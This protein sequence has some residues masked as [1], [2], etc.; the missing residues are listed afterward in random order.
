MPH[1]LKQVDNV[2]HAEALT[3]S[4]VLPGRCPFR[5]NRSTGIK[6]TPVCFF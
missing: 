3:D 4:N 5:M 2:S 1:M 6:W